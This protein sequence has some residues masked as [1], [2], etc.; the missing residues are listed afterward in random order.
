MWYHTFHYF[1]HPLHFNPNNLFLSRRWIRS[2]FLY[3]W[4]IIWIIYICIACAHTKLFQRLCNVNNVW[5]D[6]V[7]MLKRRCVCVLG[8]LIDIHSSF[9][10]SGSWW[11]RFRCIL[12]LWCF[13]LLLNMWRAIENFLFNEKHFQSYHAVCPKKK[14]YER[15]VN[16]FS[17]H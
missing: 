7:R 9:G 15:E 11:I 5:N 4:M 10:I 2:L 6:V 14:K 12:L 8:E 17:N 3:E 1:C 16:V 13:R